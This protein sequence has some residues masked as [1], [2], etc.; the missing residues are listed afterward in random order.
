MFNVA[1]SFFL[2]KDVVQGSS[3]A[4][5]TSVDLYFKEKPTEGRS[6][7]GMNKPGVYINICSVVDGVPDLNTV[8]YRTYARVGLD[9]IQISSTAATPTK[10]T[11]KTPIPFETNK[12]YAILI[13]FDG[14]DNGFVLWKN[15]SNQADVITGQISKVSS[16]KVDGNYFQLSNGTSVTRNNEVDLTFRVNVAKFTGSRS[17]TFVICNDAYE[18]FT[19]V[20]G[21]VNGSFVGGEYVY[22]AQANL[23]GSITV[24]SGSPNVSGSGTDFVTDI[25]NGDIVVIGN[26]SVSQVRQV[27]IVT[28]TSFMNVKTNFATSVASANF[29]SYETG[30]ISVDTSSNTITGTGTSFSSVAVGSCVMITDGTD[31]NTEMRKVTSVNLVTNQLVLDVKPSFTNS[32][33]AWFISPSA[34]VEKFRGYSDNLVLNS[35]AANS[36]VYFAPGRILKSVDFQANAVISAINNLSLAAYTPAYNIVLPAGTSSKYYVNFANSSYSK[37]DSNIVEVKNRTPSFVNNYPARIASRSNEVQNSS[38]LFANS[39]SMNSTLTFA[40]D[41]PFVS[42]YVTENNLDFATTEFS[43]NNSST[44]EAYANGSA[45]TR[46]ISKTVTLGRDQIAEDLIIYLTAF[47]PSGTDI[48]VYVR[49]LSDED[50]EFITDKNWTKLKLDIPSGSSV[51]SIDSNP[52]DLVELKYTIPNYSTGTKVTAGTFTTALATN[53]ITSSFS[54]VNTSIAVG[55]LVR[56]YSPTFPDTYF[57]DVV[58]ASNTTTF[59]VSDTI[60]NSDVVGVGLS[61]DVIAEKNTAFLNNQNYNV[62]RYFNSSSAK[63]DGY[64]AFAVKI[65]LLADNYYLVPRVSEYRAIAVSA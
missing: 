5:L 56:V 62:V 16:G 50:N 35:S 29:H 15:S 2:D 54:T 22:Q 1:Q 17:N 61:V 48:E 20:S 12:E 45:N 40:S 42:P 13:S 53:V 25:A 52:R 49:L 18:F 59:T 64:K 30:T 32:T 6:A 14:N 27:N 28:N 60:S 43:I 7:S 9:E 63:Y 39:K 23:T 3:V 8:N 37:S 51:N 31:D 10:F 33:A 57:V 47:K 21:S 55:D 36:T 38:N 19:L 26:S 11:F 58:T 24:S 4:F 44:N 65:V 41:N 46:Y 34:K